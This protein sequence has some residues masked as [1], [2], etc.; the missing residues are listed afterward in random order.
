[1]SETSDILAEIENAV[2]LG[3]PVSIMGVWG[4]VDLNEWEKYILP[5]IQALLSTHCVITEDVAVSA[6]SVLETEGFDQDAEKFEAEIARIEKDF[7][8]VLGKSTIRP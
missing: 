6:Q 3:R 5:R 7:R 4:R 8:P 2:E 1:M